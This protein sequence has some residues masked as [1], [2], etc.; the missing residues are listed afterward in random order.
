VAASEGLCEEQLQICRLSDVLHGQ[1]S[2]SPDEAA[3][4]GEAT[5][6]RPRPLHITAALLSPPMRATLLASSPVW[7]EAGV[8]GR[9]S[10]SA[11]VLADAEVPLLVQGPAGRGPPRTAR[12]RRW[13]VTSQ[14]ADCSRG[15]CCG[16]RASPLTR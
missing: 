7:H 2:G 13:S 5:C 6:P 11:P 16:A 14:S 15:S 10:L 8:P 3:P 12:W 4:G 9:T 1:E